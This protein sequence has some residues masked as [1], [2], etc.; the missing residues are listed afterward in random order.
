MRFLCLASRHIIGISKRVVTF[1]TGKLGVW[2]HWN[3][4]P[5]WCM[6]LYREILA[7]NWSFTINV[8]EGLTL[9][10]TLP[11]LM[12]VKCKKNLYVYSV[13]VL[14]IYF[15]ILW[16]SICTYLHH[17]CRQRLE[18]KSNFYLRDSTH[19]THS[20]NFSCHTYFLTLEFRSQNCD[21]ALFKKFCPR[22]Q[23]EI[24]PSTG[25]LLT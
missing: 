21:T 3:S 15:I 14:L 23:L 20:Q 7:E 10:I 17:F 9:P 4:I 12:I 13:L 1:V 16:P 19:T 11:S 22:S 18:K 25:T 6:M 2:L 5:I 8:F 24:K